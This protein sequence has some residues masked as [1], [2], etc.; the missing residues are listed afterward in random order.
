MNEHNSLVELIRDN[1]W[2]SY[3]I[4]DFKSK[5]KKGLRIHTVKSHS[6][7]SVTDNHKV[8]VKFGGGMKED[9]QLK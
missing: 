9:N 8:L 4:C 3:D 7:S 2:F 1:N 5:S 6:V